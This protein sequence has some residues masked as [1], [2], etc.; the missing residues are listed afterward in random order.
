MHTLSVFFTN[1]VFFFIF[2][3][4]LFEDCWI[5][6]GFGCSASFSH[7]WCLQGMCYQYDLKSGHIISC[8][9]PVSS[10]MKLMVFML[11]RHHKCFCVSCIILIIFYIF[12][13]LLMTGIAVLKVDDLGRKPLLIGGVSGIVCVYPHLSS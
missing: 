11:S 8:Y 12:S 13:Q 7:Y 6:C 1:L 10:Y 9:I 5:L 2:I 3:P 4:Q